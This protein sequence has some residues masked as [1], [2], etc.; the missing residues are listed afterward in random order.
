MLL[1]L[2]IS[3]YPLPKNRGLYIPIFFS[4]CFNFNPNQHPKKTKYKNIL[5]IA[6]MRSTPCD[7]EVMQ[8]LYTFTSTAQPNL[9]DFN[10]PLVFTCHFEVCSKM[11]KNHLLMQFYLFKRPKIVHL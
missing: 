10:I 4:F 9:T 3:P 7:N 6:M 11:H 2:N 8:Y 1:T 5:V